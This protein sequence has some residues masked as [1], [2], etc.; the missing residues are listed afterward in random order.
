[1]RSDRM[2][3]S[4][5]KRTTR[6]A[7]V[8]LPHR[9]CSIGYAVTMV[10]CYWFR[11][12][13]QTLWIDKGLLRRFYWITTELNEGSQTI[14]WLLHASTDGRNDA[15]QMLLRNQRR[16]E[17]GNNILHTLLYYVHPVRFDFIKYSAR[18]PTNV[19]LLLKNKVSSFLKTS[20]FSSTSSYRCYLKQSDE[21]NYAQTYKP[22]EYCET[23]ERAW[24]LIAWTKDSSHRL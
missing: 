2:A 16:M 13:T 6:F 12:I 4:I 10:S 1:M 18:Y 11:R 7:T 14:A 22:S 8:L 17:S 3:V 15:T 20:F 23:A 5:W 19:S 24:H 9:E 21:N